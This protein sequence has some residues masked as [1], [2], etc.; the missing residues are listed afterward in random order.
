MKKKVKKLALNKES[1]RN[2]TTDDLKKV[3]GGTG[4]TWPKTLCYSCDPTLCP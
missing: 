2:L 1:V 4:N 3:A